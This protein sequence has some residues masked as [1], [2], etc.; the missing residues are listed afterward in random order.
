MAIISGESVKKEWSQ[1]TSVYNPISDL[2]P[3]FF[4][5]RRGPK[6]ENRALVGG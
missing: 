2:E 1:P 3:F 6:K 4:L 5:E